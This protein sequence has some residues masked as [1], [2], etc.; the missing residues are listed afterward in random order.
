MS[1]L[2]T[3]SL[4]WTFSLTKLMGC[5]GRKLEAGCIFGQIRELESGRYFEGMC[6]GQEGPLKVDLMLKVQFASN[7]CIFSLHGWR[8]KCTASGGLCQSLKT[9]P[10][11]N[12]FKGNVGLLSQGTYLGRLYVCGLKPCKKRNLKDFVVKTNTVW[13][14]MEKNSLL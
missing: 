5:K 14:P 11:R 4:Q 7:S 9:L 13:M 6:S 12:I 10:I 3:K 8:R 2:E 1:L